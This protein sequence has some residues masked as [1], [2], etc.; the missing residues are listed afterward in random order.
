MGKRSGRRKRKLRRSRDGVFFGVCKGFAEWRDM[1]VDLVRI[2]F[3][4]LNVFGFIPLWVYF[5]LALVLPPEPRGWEESG[6]RER[7]NI[8]A[9]FKEFKEFKERS[10]RSWGGKFDKERDWDDRFG[11]GR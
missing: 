3:V 1:P 5:V 6:Y 7:D 2:A 4:A 10:G 11:G 9:E 8:D